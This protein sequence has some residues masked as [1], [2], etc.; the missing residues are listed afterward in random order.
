MHQSWGT[1]LSG[2]Y[3]RK[4]T[5]LHT[6]QEIRFW[7]TFEGLWL[8]WDN[9]ENKPRVKN[10]PFY[11]TGKKYFKNPKKLKSSSNFNKLNISRKIN[12]WIQTLQIAWSYGYI[13]L[14]HP[15]LSRP[16]FFFSLFPALICILLFLFLFIIFFSFCTGVQCK[17]TSFLLRRC[18]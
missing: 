13:L 4:P 17:P 10:P 11:K 18:S 16:L 5:Q 15:S 14:V 2:T 7:K 1:G 8:I 3:F 9:T 6:A 12:V